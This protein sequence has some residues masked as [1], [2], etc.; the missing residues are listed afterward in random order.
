MQSPYLA[1][2]VART[3]QVP[4]PEL[5]SHLSK[6]PRTW[7]FPRG[8]LY[9]WIGVL[10]R[11]D[12]ILAS[13]IDRYGLNSGPQ[14]KPFGRS[15]LADSY[16]NEA[17]GSATA[18]ID[19]KLNALG[20]GPEGDRELLE[21]ILSFS[22]LL[23]EKCGNRSLYSSSDRLND[24][25]NTTSTSLL[26]VTLRLGLSLA[27]RYHARQRTASS[28]HFQQS[29]L[30]AHYNIDLERV[31]KL[32]SPF[33]RPT[34]I[35]KPTAAPASPAVLTKGKEKAVPTKYDAN[36]II[37]S[38][39]ENDGWEEWGN[40]RAVY[41]PSG[42]SDQARTAPEGAG[43]DQTQHSPATPT[44]LRRSSAT[45]P[46]S[47][48]SRMSSTD[49]SPVMH[50]NS[51]SGKPE[52]IG[53]GSKVVEIPSIR[54]SSSRAEDILE[55]KLPEVPNESK[56]DFL[57][58][59]RIARALVDSRSSRENILAIRILAITNLAY[60]Y[61]DA[62]FQ[63]KILQQD[64]DQPK[65][66]QLVYQLAELVHLGASGDLATS[67]TTQTLAL[68]ALDALAKHKSRAADVCAALSVNVNH[69]VLM[70]LIR[71]AIKDLGSGDVDGDDSG[72]DE[73]RDALFALLRTLPGSSSR[74][75]ETLVAAGLIPM[76]VDILNLRTEKARRVYPRVL[77]FLD[78]FVH[79]V[80]DALSTLASA[81]G[82]DAIS[83]LIAFEAKT[84]FD[85]VSQGAGI[86]SE[87]RTPSVDYEI[88]Y[89]Q[90]QS[91]RWL[92]RFVNHIMQH[93]GGG[94]DRLLRNLV[95]SPPLLTALR[96]VFENARVFGSHVWSGAVNLLSSFIHNEPT[97]Y[98]VIAEAGLSKSFLEAVVLRD[99]NVPEVPE[100]S[101][102][103]DQDPSSAR[104]VATAGEWAHGDAKTPEYRLIR[105]DTKPLARGILP[106]TEAMSCIPQAFG[107]I[108]LN[109]SG[110]ELFQ[111]SSALE[112]YFEIFESPEHVKCM[113]DDA[114]LV[115]S[116]GTTFDE[117]VRHHPALKPSVMTAV[118]VMLARVGLLCK[119][120]AQEH[121]AGAKLWT[122]DKDGKQSVVGGP[123][124]LLGEIGVPFEKLIE[125]SGQLS[126]PE[127]NETTLPN[128]G[129][130]IVGDVNQLGLPENVPVETTDADRHG[131]TVA[132]YLY[133]VLRFLGAFFENQTNCTYFIESGGVELVLDFATLPTLPFDF[134][135]SEANHEL[136][137]LVHMLAE[138]KPHLVMPSLVKRAQSAV[139]N[140]IDFWQESKP[141]GFFTSLTKPE[142]EGGDGSDNVEVAKSR[143]TYFAK[144]L[145][146]V[147]ILT[148]IL[149]EVY[150]PPMYQT[151]PSQ[152]ASVFTQVNL[153]D[154]YSS[155]VTALGH[156]HAACVWEEILLQ[157]N[158]PERWNEATKVRGYDLGNE[159]ANDALGLLNTAPAIR[160]A[161][162]NDGDV[163]VSP[164]GTPAQG[165]DASGLLKPP[166]AKVS[167][168]GAAFKNAQTLRYLLSHLPSS[169]TG[170]FHLLGHGIIGKRRIDSYQRQ[171]ATMVADSIASVVL[172]QLQLGAP[173]RSSNIKDRF[174]YLIVIL[175]TFSQLLFESEFFSPCG[176]FLGLLLLTCFSVL[177]A[178]ERS[179]SHCLTLILLAFKKQNGLKV[180]KGLCD[181]FLRE[182]RALAP[183]VGHFDSP[184]QSAR[185]ASAYGGLK[186]ILTF[187]SEITSARYI[188][189]SNQTQA[190]TG[191]ERE[192][193]RP[194]YFHPGQFLV[195]L[196]MEV[197]PMV[198]E[199]W[200]SD[201]VD[202][203][204]SSIVK[205]L[206]DILRS[207]LDGEYES[208]AARRSDSPQFLAETVKKVFTINRERLATLRDRDFDKDL[209]REALY[210]C[211]N[212]L[213]AAEEYCKAQNWLRPPAR[214]PPPPKDIAAAP[215]D[216]TED[217]PVG[218]APP[219]AGGLLDHS[220]LAMLLAQAAGRSTEDRSESQQGQNRAGEDDSGNR[221]DFLARALHHILNDQE[222]LISDTVEE[223]S[224]E[225]R[226]NPSVEPASQPSEQP[227][228]RR[229]V[230][231]IDDLDSERDKVRSNLI[232]RC[233]DVLNVHH[234]VTFEL[235][236]LIAAATKKHRDPDGFRKEAGETL[237][238]SLVSLQTEDDLR[239]SGK[240]IAAY[241][242]LLALV[243]QDKDI[244]SATVG[245]L[246]DCF[247]TLLGFIQI[248]PSDKAT[249]E[250]SPW[251][252][253]VLL[254]I[255][256][257]LSDDAQP[258]QIRWNPPSFDGPDV[259]E[260]PA[261]LEEPL[262]SLDEKTQ[263]FEA[264]LEIL[265]RIGKDDSLA[266]SV[267]R[268]FVML[269][270]NR[271]IAVR[272]GE[273]R[274]L[275]RLFVMVKQLASSTNEKLQ[276]AFML[277]LR[278]I[279]EDEETIR[280]I[281]RSEIVA[282]FETRS[283]RQTDTTGYVRHLY[284]LVLRSPELFVEVTNE[285]LK[286][287]RYDSHQRPQVLVLKTD[288]ADAS[289][290]AP[291][292]PKDGGNADK[293]MET[294]TSGET[295]APT[296]RKE[297]GK[298]AELKPPVV[299]HPDGVIHYL[300][301]ELLSYKDV[302]DKEPAPEN[303]E[304]DRSEPQTDVEM[305]NGEPSPSSSTAD[306]TATRSSKKPEKASFKAE[307]H[308]IYI[309][310]CFLL[311]CLTELLS[312]Y[313]RTK[314][315][316]INF[317][318][319]ADPLAATPSKPR[320]G[321][322][323]YLL[324]VLIPVGTLEHDESVAFKKRSNTSACTMRVIVALCT[325][326]GEFGGLN[327]RRASEDEEEE[328]ELLFVRRFALEHALKSYRDA[329]ASNELLDVKY[330][331]LMCL[332]DLFDKMLSG[333][334]FANGDNSFPSSTRLLAKTMFEKHFISA[335]TASIADIDLNFPAS[336][337][338]IKYILRPLNKLTQTAVILSETTSISTPGETEEDEISS[339]TSVSDM[340]DD[341]EETPDLFRHSTLGML[342]PSHEEET[343]EEESEE[344]DE[345]YDD[346]YGDEMDY[347]EDLPEDD[348]EVVS[349]EDED[350]E[351]RGPIEGLP[352]DSGM[353][354]EVL[355]DE[356]EDDEDDDE[357]DDDEDED[358]DM[359]E[360][361]EMMAG[362]IT[363]DHDN[364]SLAEDDDDE[365]ESEDMSE[366]NEEAEML[367]QFENEL[368]DIRQ[369][370]Q[371]GDAQRF[372]DLFRVLHEA[373]GGVDDFRAGSLGGD[374]QD[375]LVDDDI[376][377][378]EG[379]S[380]SLAFSWCSCCANP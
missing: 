2:F 191:N 133:P 352:G 47:R 227:P 263:L 188:V 224:T 163:A 109:S 321:V 22:L 237:V 287:Q 230:T 174:S 371:H 54:V 282:S 149:R 1:D 335:L 312:S 278:H 132:N 331:R 354:I 357:E 205:C 79:A 130:L 159:E 37:S 166:M 63:Q 302:D 23:Q 258:P 203:A 204:S 271:S 34:I 45:L 233:L 342:E 175:S 295:A 249:E 268:V 366:D 322:L 334:T 55:S 24:L 44:P 209:A 152:Q 100:P 292:A 110:L 165:D 344:D 135:N 139:D 211:N 131:L 189:E 281:M 116:L 183:Q 223:P 218:D 240:K 213:S 359:D 120:K 51:P 136:T 315:E 182:I 66:L 206:V 269:T 76:F 368:E 15:V 284:H 59:V 245:E 231:T 252:G 121:G 167:E 48:L 202:Q 50:G 228:R 241:A 364:D 257:L 94:F 251:I 7:P 70:F 319:K 254:V 242:N 356:D 146:A 97:S 196:R 217:T 156:L 148:E 21:A 168:D 6:L 327:K 193:D 65:R 140:I 276:S 235:A 177:A 316:F 35:T 74:T 122:Q 102:T 111:A 20:Y 57:H 18:D 90:Q 58:R 8:D 313:N 89:F 299:E 73:W 95:D 243:L 214:L 5:P 104:A 247:I 56:Y 155:L 355:L 274:N 376:N 117:L 142:S 328:P 67:R 216:S 207:A 210:R 184:D 291:S 325:R 349:D 199:L 301:S 339:A 290:G 372:E 348:G 297:K 345:L 28:T 261:Q 61:P 195:D 332:A 340:D 320:S 87:F 198:R 125:S 266:L 145:V 101:A 194:D 250:P 14:T 72:Q 180:M 173:N 181:V 226:G 380:A 153:A 212:V 256:K 307:E 154:R 326:T 341:R 80:R 248:P 338:V 176:L 112:S 293:I 147:H 367:N 262:I 39:R 10:D 236:D 377:E 71:K 126:P 253:Q 275:Q 351:G 42:S 19:A 49:E 103:S 375:D 272:M 114:N 259:N 9:H 106:A 201:F 151:R 186:I 347:D 362:E 68:H 379:K 41:Y 98:A 33:P 169:I 69:G 358:S 53:R 229:E 318:R 134:R 38:L 143:G 337:R 273:K 346:E 286:L 244:Y 187:F 127:L 192:R 353:D 300:L 93:S 378:D 113:K 60:V 267:C 285:K 115:R 239:S 84:A 333:Y 343:S 374:V 26:L 222:N 81:K 13:V 138:T 64:S 303:V 75:P 221:A 119:R 105:P 178:A 150:T 179:H 170:F 123:S 164:E 52:E 27:Q 219:F 238:Q 260:E 85:N 11:F 361:D 370:D 373:A 369:A 310:R 220:S 86:S 225:N 336:K 32:A 108:C 314:V 31:Q 137:Q 324:N 161:A 144:H 157:K 62:L 92:F 265:P 172:R 296:E 215:G 46:T 288:K 200:S 162:N 158:I 283:S 279:V 43:S 305:S 171:N 107:A 185:L 294:T 91:L 190:L 363:G 124:S 30:A 128:G 129:K 323:N 12:E 365:W 96:L 99:L 29:L 36:D 83:E 280:Q 330:S 25:L 3:A 234:D 232:E 350:I 82:F 306:L 270:R 17:G 255:E 208:G 264:L 88:P 289:A 141:S 77:E 16:A 78:T 311:Q 298:L 329:M 4:I 160:S 317:S 308:P 309:Y 40:I 118:I 304:P 197:L 277:I 360:D 246:K